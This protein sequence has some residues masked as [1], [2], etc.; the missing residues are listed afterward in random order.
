MRTAQVG[1]YWVEIFFGE[2]SPDENFR[3]G[4]ILVTVSKVEVFIF[5][6][7]RPKSLEYFF[8]LFIYVSK[9]LTALY[10]PLLIRILCTLCLIPFENTHLFSC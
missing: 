2:N 1:V 10:F 8:Y 9:Y 7:S 6:I 4:I 3:M 5:Q